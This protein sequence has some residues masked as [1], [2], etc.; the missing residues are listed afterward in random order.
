MKTFQ[1]STEFETGLATI[2][3]EHQQLVTLI[4]RLGA[5]FLAGDAA[6]EPA[7][8]GVFNELSEYAKTH[9]GHEE[10][11]MVK[12]RLAPAYIARHRKVHVAFVEQLEVLWRSRGS[13][14]EPGE[15]LLG[16]LVEWLGFHILREDQAMA[17]QVTSIR[18]GLAP[19][20]ALEHANA[21]R[22]TGGTGALVNALQGLYHTLSLVN[23]AL[24]EANR[25]LESRVAERTRS[26]AEAN[27]ALEDAYRKMEALARVDG[28][29]GI[30]NRRHFDERLDQEWRRAQR[31]RTELGLLMIDVDH[32]KLYNDAYG[33]QAGDD[34]LKAVVQCLGAGRRP[35]DLLARYGGE[36]LVLMLPNTAASGALVVAREVCAAVARAQIP[37]RA[38][39]VAEVV[40]V[41]VGVATRTPSVGSSSALLLAA[42]DAALYEAKDQGRN[43]V[44]ADAGT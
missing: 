17:A 15:V 4:N 24:L 44:V 25:Q 27:S 43:R 29:L 38:S 37:H 9:F 23:G 6:G 3:D 21:Q 13:M 34:C 36:E 18:G 30:A 32:F 28:L 10:L 19:E 20:E 2:D 16:F 7:L 14:R 39:P 5:S 33:H 26:L 11:L 40:T 22:N 8:D 1:W 12:A 31:E 35:A 42:A 41:S